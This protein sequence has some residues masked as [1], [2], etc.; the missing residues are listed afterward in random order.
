MSTETATHPAEIGSRV[1][2]MGSAKGRG[3]I[4]HLKTTAGIE[5]AAVQWDNYTRGYLDWVAVR[6]LTVMSG[7]P[8][9]DPGLSNAL[10]AL[11]VR[12]DTARASLDETTAALD[13]ER[14]RPNTAAPGR[15]VQALRDERRSAWARLTEA[16]ECLAVVERCR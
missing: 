7:R 12:V 14:A 2:A 10:V 11:Q 8:S 3:T 13:A 1:I 16:Q 15:G 4:E 6:D 5:M 9:I